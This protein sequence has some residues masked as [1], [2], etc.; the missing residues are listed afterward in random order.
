MNSDRLSYI[1]K[2]NLSDRHSYP[3]AKTELKIQR[4]TFFFKSD[5]AHYLYTFI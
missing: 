5:L 1:E 4:L 3:A 2:G